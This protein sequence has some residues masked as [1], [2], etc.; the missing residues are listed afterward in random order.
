[1][2]VKRR[3]Q[4]RYGHVVGGF[5]NPTAYEEQWLTDWHITASQMLLL[6]QFPNH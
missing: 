1:M 3:L 4:W 6:K 2:L 5:L